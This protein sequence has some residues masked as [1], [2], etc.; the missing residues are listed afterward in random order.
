MNKK[1]WLLICIIAI[2]LIA[3]SIIL[4]MNRNTRFNKLVINESK[5][6]NIIKDREESNDIQLDNLIFN[7][8]NLIIDNENNIIYYSIV[9]GKE[10]ENPLIKYDSNLNIAMSQEIK[11]EDIDSDSNIKIMVYDKNKYR[12][13]SLVVTNYPWINFQTKEESSKKN[14]VEIEVFDNHKGNMQR[15]VK[16][17]GKLLTDQG[18]SEYIFSLTKES[19][20][21]NKRKNIISIL[22]M[23]RNNEFKLTKTQEQ[24][25]DKKYVQV[26]INNEY[27]GLYEIE[28]KGNI[29]KS[30]IEP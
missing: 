7:D 2:A 21:R 25:E 24:Q 16:S 10:K 11:E 6:N 15:L 17:D 28:E 30:D 3:V 26:F 27:K 29:K 5:W 13:Y 19:L 1:K 12:I 8:Y 4:L 18:D 20:G 14:A 22:G 9:D 23:N